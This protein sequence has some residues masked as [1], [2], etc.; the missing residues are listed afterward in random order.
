MEFQ[1]LA[2]NRRAPANGSCVWEER[3]EL[4][5]AVQGVLEAVAAAAARAGRP[6]DAVRVVA[7]SKF[8]PAEAVQEVVRAGLRDV[9]E[10][11][12]QEAR[13]KMRLVAGATWHMVGRLQANKAALAARLFD[14]LHSLDRAELV[15]VIGSAAAKRERPLSVLVQVNLAGDARK[16]GCAPADVAK[17]LRRCRDH[18]MLA[19]RGL[20]VVPPQEE[21]P[22]PHFAAL[23]RLREQLQAE[24]PEF[25]LD[26]LSMGMSGDFEAAIAE[27]ATMVR[28]GTAIFG[29][30]Q[31]G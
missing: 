6:Q 20:M 23:R 13:A 2:G 27:G 30:R 31:G 4:A 24:F 18:A 29:P 12:V 16:G 1:P 19:P 21:E 25:R 11:R 5:T 26:Q 15:P 14:W 17:I 7:I 28:I 22:R 8:H 3:P 9:G 10:N